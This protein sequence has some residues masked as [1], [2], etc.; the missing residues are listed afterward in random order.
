MR[1]LTSWLMPGWHC[2]WHT[3]RYDRCVRCGAV[4]PWL[5]RDE[6]AYLHWPLDRR[7]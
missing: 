3:Y 4:V 7:P 2:R 6:P 5:L 1:R